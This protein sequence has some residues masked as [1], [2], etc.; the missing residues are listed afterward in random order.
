MIKAFCQISQFFYI[1]RGRIGNN[2][3]GNCRFKN[4]ADFSDFL[5]LRAIGRINMI[6]PVGNMFDETLLCKPVKGTAD[7]I[8][9]PVVTLFEV[10]LFK[11]TVC[12]ENTGLDV[13]QNQIGDI[14][15]FTLGSF[16]HG[17]I[18]FWLWCHCSPL[19]SYIKIVCFD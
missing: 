9:T 4:D 16:I 19:I 15:F 11:P 5:G 8:A 7:F 12:R 2:L 3:V 6:A 1:A 10:H 17:D 18:V 13:V 14:G